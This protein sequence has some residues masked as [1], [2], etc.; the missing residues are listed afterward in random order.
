MIDQKAV[1]D[2]GNDIVNGFELPAR[3]ATIRELTYNCSGFNPADCT[4]ITA[5]A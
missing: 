3:T 4:K 2:H 5:V 1:K